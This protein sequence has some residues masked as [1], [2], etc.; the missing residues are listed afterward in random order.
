M[1][2]VKILVNIILVSVV[3]FSSCT[4]KKMVKMATEQQLTVEPS[5]LE[6]HGGEV[7]F[8]MSALLPAGMLKKNTLYT[9]STYYQYGDQ[10]L[11]L[12]TIEFKQTD[13]PDKT[14]TPKI[15]KKFS[16]PYKDEYKRGK[17]MVVGAAAKVTGKSLPTPAM[18]VADGT[19]TTSDLVEDETYAMYA[20]HGYNNQE[21]LI[22]TNVE[23]F[24]SGNSAKLQTRESR[25]HRPTSSPLETFIHYLLA[26]LT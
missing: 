21:E 9:V 25:G 5:P 11:D 17:V 22:P 10:K 20:G 19:I 4:L 15:S 1:N 14:I 26:S 24:F 23:F 12:G 3:F 16:F 13:F 2:K 8:E 6:L 7:S 18:E